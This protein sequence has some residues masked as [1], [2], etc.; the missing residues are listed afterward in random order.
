MYYKYN[1]H[2]INKYR[3]ELNDWAQSIGDFQITFLCFVPTEQLIKRMLSE[4]AIIRLKQTAPKM[5]EISILK[6]PTIKCK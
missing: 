2:Y 3:K 6:P 5:I 1:Y 4:G